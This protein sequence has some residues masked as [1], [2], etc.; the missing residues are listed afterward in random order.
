[1]K[2]VV[3]PGMRSLTASEPFSSSS[4]SGTCPSATIRSSSET[5]RARPL[6]PGELVVLEEVAGGEPIVELRLVRNQ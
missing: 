1:M 3:E 6:A 2:I 5:E 4:S